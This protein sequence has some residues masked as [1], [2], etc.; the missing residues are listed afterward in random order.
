MCFS[1]TSLIVIVWTGIGYALSEYLFKCEWYSTFM[2]GLS[3]WPRVAATVGVAIGL[4]VIALLS[5]LATFAANLYYL[6]RAWSPKHGMPEK[7]LDFKS[8]LLGQKWASTPI[9]VEVR[10]FLCFWQHQPVPYPDC[11]CPVLHFLLRQCMSIIFR[12]TL[13]SK[14]M[15]WRRCVTIVASSCPSASICHTSSSS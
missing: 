4:V 1:L 8:K 7:Y 10:T 2:N 14:A 5:G 3:P 13:T 12:E 6:A 15:C 11:L 9:P